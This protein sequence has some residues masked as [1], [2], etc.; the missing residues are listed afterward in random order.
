MLLSDPGLS[1]VLSPGCHLLTSGLHQWLLLGAGQWQKVLAN[2]VH[3]SEWPCCSLGG[4][5]LLY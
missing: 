1:C 5:A 3:L 2:S 4:T